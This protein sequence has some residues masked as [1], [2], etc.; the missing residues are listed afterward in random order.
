MTGEWLPHL[1]KAGLLGEPVAH[2]PES[3]GDGW[4][5]SDWPAGSYLLRM[6]ASTDIGTRQ[7]VV[8][9]LRSVAATDHPDIRQTGIAIL[10]ALP[11]RRQPHS[12][13]S[14]LH[15]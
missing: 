8:P 11:A 3:A 9:A 15:G 4:R 13:I 10:A 12:L 1:L 2:L 7:E 6:A 5:Y 14:R